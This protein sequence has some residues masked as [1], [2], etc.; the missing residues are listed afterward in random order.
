MFASE[1][2]L[3]E[4][5]RAEKEDHVKGAGILPDKQEISDEICRMMHSSMMGTITTSKGSRNCS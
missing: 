1:W 5:K 2:I 3:R 4:T